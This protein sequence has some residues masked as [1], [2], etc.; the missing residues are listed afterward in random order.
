MWR[1]LLAAAASG[2]R[3]LH[4]SG[5]GQAHL[6]ARRAPAAHPQR[7]DRRGAR[8]TWRRSSCAA[9]TW[10]SCMP[11][12][13][14]RRWSGCATWSSPAAAATTSS[15]RWRSCP[16]CTPQRTESRPHALAAALYAYAYLFPDDPAERPEGIDPRFRWAC[17]IYAEGLTQALR[18]PGAQALQRGGRHVPAA[19][20]HPDRHVRR[21]AS[22]CWGSRML[23]DLVPVSEYE[24]YGLR[25]RY[26]QPGIGV[27]LAAQTVPLGEGTPADRLIEDKVRVPATLV[28]RLDHPRQQIAATA[29]RRATRSVRGHRPRGG[30][31]RRHR[32]AAGD[33]PHRDRRD[34]AVRDRSSG[35][36]RWPISSARPPACARRRGWWRASPIGRGAFRW[37]SCT[38]RTRATAA[39]PTWSTIC[40]NDPR[41][42]RRY[43][44]WFF[45]YDSGNPIAY[46]A[47][48]LRRALRDAVATFDPDGQR[49]LSAPDGR[50]RPQS[51]RPAHQDDGDRLGLR[52]LGRHE[53]DALRSAAH[54][55]R[56]ARA[57]A[58]DAVREAA[59]VRRPRRV[60]RHAAPRQLHGQ[61]RPRAPPGRQ[62][63]QHA[64]R[65]HGRRHRSLRRARSDQAAGRR[66]SAF[67]PASTT[68]RRATRSSRRCRAFPIAPGVAAHS[69]I[70]VQGDGPLDDG[71]D[72]VVAYRARTSTASSR[73]A[74]CAPRRIRPSRTPRPSTRCA[75]SCCCRPTS[76]RAQSAPPTDKSELQPQ[77]EPR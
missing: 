62:A 1:S 74:W 59:A 50:D 9:T 55:G 63:D 71:V 66:S 31:D 77:P 14:R 35:T 65:D 33:R 46:S 76:T 56:V 11:T 32:G 61:L 40:E 15:T 37:C 52:L 23:T 36:R 69:I 72:G 13:P 24:I 34:H 17:D 38:A 30:R 27:A 45:T 12:T 60:H 58:G 39:G 26:R 49:P 70:P 2:R 22:W 75:A 73:S 18:E 8:A 25:N 41:I 47:M 42:R 7:A 64:A 51:G 5:G 53:R 10:S 54:V 67:R 19:L 28:L 4:R 16:I 44:F 43:Q 20:R 29:L 3:R 68:C 6:G 48:L 57:A 21:R